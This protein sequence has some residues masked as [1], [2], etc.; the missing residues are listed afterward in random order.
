L[1]NAGKGASAPFFNWGCAAS[2][3][4]IVEGFEN[5]VA[6]RPGETILTSLLRAGLPFPFACQTGTCGTCKCLLVY[7]DV[8]EL[9]R[10]ERA[11][12]PE[13]RE[14]GIVLACRTQLLGRGTIR[15]ID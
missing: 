4:L 11:L 8:V 2:D 12:R 9:P 7:G 5:P 6:V 15:R 3:E 14:K 13:E 10:S 1:A